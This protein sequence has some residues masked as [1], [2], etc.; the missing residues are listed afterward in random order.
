MRLTP[1]QI[2]SIRRAAQ[3]VLGPQVSIRLFGSRARNDLK[4]GDIDLLFETEHTVPNRAQAICSIQGALMRTLGD[5]KIDIVLK[6]ART[7]DAAVFKIARRT[8]VIL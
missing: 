2:E 7:P 3:S 5:R 6:D 1:S 4:G 8:G